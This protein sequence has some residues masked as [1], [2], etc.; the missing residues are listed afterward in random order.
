VQFEAEYKLPEQSVSVMNDNKPELP[1]NEASL[2]VQYITGMGTEVHTIFMH[3]ACTS[4]ACRPFLSWILQ[5]ANTSQPAFVQ[6]ISV[7]TTEHEYVEAMGDKFV[8]RVNQEFQKAGMRGISLLFATGDKASQYYKGKYWINFPSC[9]PYVTAV[10]GVWLGDLGGGPMSVDHDTTGG[11]AN[12]ESHLQPGYQKASV[13]AYLA[14]ATKH[15]AKQPPVFNS[16]FRLF[17]P[18]FLPLSTPHIS[19][20]FDTAPSMKHTLTLYG[21]LCFTF[22]LMLAELFRMCQR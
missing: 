13:E 14:E 11:F 4:E 3:Y 22:I 21:R 7:G 17:L 20:H 9:S 6:S 10:G 5:Q 19:V 16:S 12:S 1:G 8:A 15:A 18:L 2:D